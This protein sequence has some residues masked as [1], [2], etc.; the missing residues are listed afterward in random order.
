MTKRP[1]L[2]NM[3]ERKAADVQPANEE[4]K[5]KISSQPKD[6]TRSRVIVRLNLE[7]VEALEEVSRDLRRATG[8]AVPIQ[9]L[10]EEAVEDLL[11]K[12]GKAAV[13]LPAPTKR[14]R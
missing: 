14:S 6:D 8:R 3:V 2:M 13:V 4:T 5:D 9:A 12:H 10:M 1:S 7:A 11:R